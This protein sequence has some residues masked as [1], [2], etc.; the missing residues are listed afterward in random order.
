[1]SSRIVIDENFDIDFDGM[2]CYTLIHKKRIT[3]EGRGSHLVKA[4][5]VG[6]TRD[7]EMGYYGTLRAVLGGYVDKAAGM[8]ATDVSS[9]L[10]GLTKCEE[11]I[12]NININKEVV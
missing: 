4:E 11:A 5:S 8:E 12:A 10:N 6:K 7:V 1:M 9:L 3:G 2:R